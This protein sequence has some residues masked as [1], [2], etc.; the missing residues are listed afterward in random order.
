MDARKRSRR[1]ANSQ[2]LGLSEQAIK[3]LKKSTNTDPVL[4]IRRDEKFDLAQSEN[5][6]F[7]RPRPSME[8]GPLITLLDACMVVKDLAKE[9]KTSL[10][11]I[12]LIKNKLLEYEYLRVSGEKK[13]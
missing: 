9:A 13:S 5:R 4:M 6:F 3:E 11:Q 1:G 10:G 2:N 12:S 7:I 8:I